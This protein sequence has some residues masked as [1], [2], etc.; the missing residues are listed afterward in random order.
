MALYLLFEAA[1]GYALFEVEGMDELAQ[2]TDALQ[3]VGLLTGTGTRAR[4]E[5]QKAGW[6][7][8][9]RGCLACLASCL[10]AVKLLSLA[11]CIGRWSRRCPQR[12][13]WPLQ[14]CSDA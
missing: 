10:S 4:Q 13:H 8:Q 5:A 1:S 12:S 6:L 3:Q 9:H 14:S 11:S 2:E 7:L